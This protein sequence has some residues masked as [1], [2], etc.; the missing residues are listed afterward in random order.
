MAK[1]WKWGIVLFMIMGLLM[2]REEA[3]MNA[4][5]ETPYLV[6]DLVTT[7]ILSACLWGG[8]LNI[9]EKTG[10]MHYFAI[11]L[12][13]LLRLI[14]GSI[15]EKEHVYDDLSANLIA[16]LLGLGSLATLS[17]LK[18]FQRLNAYNP[19]PQRPTR[20]MLTL[21]IMNTA[22]LCLFPTSLIMLRKQF[23]STSL[24]AFYPYMLMISITI[25]I[26]GLIIQRVIDHE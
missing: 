21:V 8:F 15:I 9:I 3:M 12:K 5:L 19:F 25:I 16:N 4:I 11:V 14:Y 22:G 20:E 26:V 23:G 7:V 13:P 2:H 18:A 10:F 17:G 1:L 24:Y 6:L